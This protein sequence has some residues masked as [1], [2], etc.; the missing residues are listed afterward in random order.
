[1][2][3]C[4]EKRSFS[5]GSEKNQ[6]HVKYPKTYLKYSE[7]VTK[8]VFVRLGVPPINIPH[9]TCLSALALGEELSAAE[10][11]DEPRGEGVH[12][13]ESGR[14]DAL[15]KDVAAL[16][17]A[18]EDVPGANILEHLRGNLASEGA[19]CD[20]VRVLAGDAVACV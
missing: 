13:L 17:V 1:M 8:N 18:D 4:P 20:R 6:K 9:L 2:N 14:L 10:N 11:N 3:Y 5:P 7:K 12:R 16:R 19:L 15:A